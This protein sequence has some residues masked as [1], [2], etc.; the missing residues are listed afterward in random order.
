M[1]DMF[2]EPIYSNKIKS[3]LFHETPFY[4][5]FYDS[6]TAASYFKSKANYSKKFLTER[7]VDDVLTALAES[8]ILKSPSFSAPTC[9]L[10]GYLFVAL[11]LYALKNE[12]SS[13]RL[14]SSLIDFATRSSEELLSIPF[15]GTNRLMST[16]DQ[17][18]T[19][20]SSSG[21][22]SD[23]LEHQNGIIRISNYVPVL[24]TVVI[25]TALGVRFILLPKKE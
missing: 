14:H 4:R 6:W 10:L 7:S 5:V 1:E 12:D 9:T 20:P 8:D 24:I 16:V 22:Q 19:S 17:A 3:L 23:L 18:T 21:N 25:V 11:R 2:A 13:L 15:R